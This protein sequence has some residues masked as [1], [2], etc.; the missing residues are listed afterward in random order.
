M[1]TDARCPGLTNG[2]P[3]KYEPLPGSK[4][5]PRHNPGLAQERGKLGGSANLGKERE[6]RIEQAS[7]LSLNT[8]EG[9]LQALTVT[10]REAFAS[11]QWD[12]AISAARAA[13][14]LANTLPRKRDAHPDLS[15]LT[16][17][18]H[19]RLVD[20]GEQDALSPSDRAE[21]KRLLD[22]AL[23]GNPA[24]DALLALN[25]LGDDVPAVKCI[26]Q[27]L[28]YGLNTG[29]EERTRHA[30]YRAQSFLRPPKR[31]D[32]HLA[33]V[34]MPRDLELA[35]EPETETEHVRVDVSETVPALPS[36]R[37]MELLRKAAGNPD[38]LSE[39]EQMEVIGAAKQLNGAI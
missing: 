4:H 33:H 21:Y 18:E 3:C 9:T 7:N 12:I 27:D 23:P 11:G 16:E 37:M 39:S 24:R 31:V 13:D 19:D 29:D 5:C 2:S 34:K 26:R 1:S 10:M 38:N 25:D 8:P 30:T 14:G 22:A 36:Q 28:E 6:R 17:R 15:R 35:D 20:F 32:H